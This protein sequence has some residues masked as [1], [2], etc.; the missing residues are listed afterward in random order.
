[1]T[2]GLPYQQFFVPSLILFI[3]SWV[4]S[5][6]LKVKIEK[7]KRNKVVAFLILPF[8][9]YLVGLVYSEN[10]AFGWEDISVKLPIVL[11]PILLVTG[12]N[13][14]EKLPQILKAFIY[15]M[16]ICCLI[17]IVYGFIKYEQLPTYSLLDAFLHPS[18]LAMYLNVAICF[19]LLLIDTNKGVFGNIGHIITLCILSITIWLS[20]S[21]SGILLWSIIVIASVTYIVFFKRRFVVFGLIVIISGIALGFVAYNKLPGFQER[22]TYALNSFN[23]KTEIDPATTESSQVRVLIWGNAIELFQENMLLGVGTGDIKD[24]LFV[25]YK[26]DGMTGALDKKLNVHNQYLQILATLGL[27]G[28]I[29]FLISIIYPLALSIRLQNLYYLSFI[30]VFGFNILFESMLEKQDGVVFYAF[31]NSLLF[32]HFKPVDKKPNLTLQSSKP[33]LK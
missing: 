23:N 7:F 26:R 28:F 30:L 22:F 17:S 11:F 9:I 8:F 6:T 25:K 13:L 29:T 18:Y 2:V 19:I 20:L 31:L 12:F 14:S 16:S 15:S 5:N 1:L 24:E 27:I 32:F 21:K 4:F 10:Q 33:S 3:L